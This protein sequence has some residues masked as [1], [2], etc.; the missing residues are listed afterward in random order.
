MF[1]YGRKGSAIDPE[2]TGISEMRVAS[3]EIHVL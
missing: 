3:E 2:D 1:S